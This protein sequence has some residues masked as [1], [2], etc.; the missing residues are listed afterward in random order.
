MTPFNHDSDEDG[1]PIDR[2]IAA[3]TGDSIESQIAELGSCLPVL[4]PG[5]RLEYLSELA[6]IEHKRQQLRVLPIALCVMCLFCVSLWAAQLGTQFIA[7]TRYPTGPKSTPV[8]ITIDSSTERTKR[9]SAALAHA[10][11]WVLVDAYAS[12]TM[13]QPASEPLQVTTRS[14][15][16]H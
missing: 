9:L 8:Q 16:R 13:Q 4:R 15:V 2:D 6:V 14:A 11:S 10:D 7:M 12:R 5:L 1:L 3:N